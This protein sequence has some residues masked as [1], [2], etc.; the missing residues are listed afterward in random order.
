ML[1]RLRALLMR[2]RDE[3]SAREEGEGW[4]ESL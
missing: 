3:W 4:R 2:L 1:E